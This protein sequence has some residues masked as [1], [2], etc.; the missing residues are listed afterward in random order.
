MLSV[1]HWFQA[2]NI[3]E[4]VEKIS[5]RAFL[6]VGARLPQLAGDPAGDAEKT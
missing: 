4:Q 2:W 6:S 3:A 1:F 5:S